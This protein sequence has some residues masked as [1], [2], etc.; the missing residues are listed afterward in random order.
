MFTPI[1]TI[2][3][4]PLVIQKFEWSSYNDDPVLL[5]YSDKGV[6]RTGSTILMNQVKDIEDK[7]KD[8][9]LKAKIVARVNK[10]GKTYYS[11]E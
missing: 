10:R 3:D 1:Q 4:K 7:L 5:I 8:S 6:I 2:L 11:L 9:S